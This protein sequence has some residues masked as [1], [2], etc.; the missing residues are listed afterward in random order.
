MQLVFPFFSYQMRMTL[1]QADGINNVV[2]EPSPGN[3]SNL[4]ETRR[5]VS[6][7]Q[8]LG[9]VSINFIYFTLEETILLV[10]AWRMSGNT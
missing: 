1:G 5:S 8:D 9:L 7:T 2:V 4:V 10:E 6:V 3:P